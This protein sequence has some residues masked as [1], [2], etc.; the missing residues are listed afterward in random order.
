MTP[1]TNPNVA[2]DRAI[3]SNYPVIVIN[4]YEE[5]RIMAE[6]VAVAKQRGRAVYD[7]TIS[8][9][10]NY[11]AGAKAPNAPAPDESEDPTAALK[12]IKE[13]GGKKIWGGDKPQPTV[14]VFKDMHRIA[15]QDVVIV[16]HLRDIVAKFQTC[17]MTLILMSPEFEVPADLA[18]DVKVLDWPLPD[19]AQI[20]E[21]LTN[22]LTALPD[23]SASGAKIKKTVSADLRKRFVA[24]LA[25]LTEFESQNVIATAIVAHGGLDEAAL[26]TVV[27]EKRAILK[28]SKYV[29]DV[30]TNMTLA[31]IGG[32]DVLKA[33]ILADLSAF[34][35]EAQAAGVDMPR[36]ILIAGVPGTGKSAIVKAI[37]GNKRRLLRLSP[38]ELL[39]SLV[40]S[41]QA[42][43][44]AAT[45]VI[46][47][48]GDCVVWIDELEKGLAGAR[49]DGG[50]SGTMRQVFGI[51]LTWMQERTS[52]AY[53]VATANDIS[54]LAP[55]LLRRFDA[56]YFVDVPNA[57][58]RMQIAAIHLRQRNQD[59]EDVDLEALAED[60]N[61]FTGGEIE[62]VVKG[63]VKKAWLAK[64]E[65]ATEDLLAEAAG[66]VPVTKSKAEEIA[67][68]RRW[69]AERAK[70]ASKSQL[71]YSAEVERGRGRVVEVE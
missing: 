36:G 22:C 42:N 32:L 6:I 57:D 12:E 48:S 30:E 25:G 47:A 62:K 71:R 27:A 23:K 54:G 41:S 17:Q 24:N 28:N 3:R 9:G 61:G 26:A 31:D 33:D 11:V 4:T 64:R 53:I 13:W 21:I 2:L 55:E 39:G 34:D 1:K 35:P 52:P 51:L 5:A 8:K 66:V 46:D 65:L 58:E 59:A 43:V 15:A 40:G 44:K 7:W 38:A 60:T 69:A 14:F 63:A 37:A 29:E 50:D 56:V 70:P 45:K 19:Q 67:S 10:L 20:E 18:K 68:L 16:R 49:S